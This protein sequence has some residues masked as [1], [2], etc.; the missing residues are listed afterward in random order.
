MQMI[1]HR[2]VILISRND[3][4][5]QQEDEYVLMNSL[6]GIPFTIYTEHCERRRGVN[7]KMREEKRHD[8]ILE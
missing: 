8:W 7:G 4:L 2:T 3:I 1:L 6:L 5:D